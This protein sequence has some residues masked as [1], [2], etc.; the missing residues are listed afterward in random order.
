MTPPTPGSEQ[1]QERTTKG[2]SGPA[3]FQVLLT[4]LADYFDRAPRGATLE[5]L[6]KFGFIVAN[7]VEKGGP[8]APSVEMDRI[9][10]AQQYLETKEKHYDHLRRYEPRLPI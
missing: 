6:Q 7:T 2:A 3:A 8:L 4:K 1:L 9:R 10:T 5:A